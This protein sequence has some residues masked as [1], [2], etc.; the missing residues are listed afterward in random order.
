MDTIDYIFFHEKPF[1]LFVEFLRQKELEPGTSSDEDSYEISLPDN[2]EDSLSEVIEKEYDRLFEMNQQLIEEA[3]PEN[4]AGV[5]VNLKDGIT[6]YADINPALL[7]K[8]MEVLTPQELG[9]V[10][11][12]IVDAVECPDDRSLCERVRDHQANQGD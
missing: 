3:S 12:A 11:N 1:K 5:V 2:L 4:A 6:T 9:D 10:V 7:S 8:I